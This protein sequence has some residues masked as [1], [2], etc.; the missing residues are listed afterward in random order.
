MALEPDPLTSDCE[1]SFPPLSKGGEEIVEVTVEVC[2]EPFIQV[3]VPGA[4]ASA[5]ADD[6]IVL[7]DTSVVLCKRSWAQAS[8]IAFKS[9]SS[10]GERQPNQPTSGW[11]HLAKAAPLPV[12]LEWYSKV[13]L[14]IKFKK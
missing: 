13:S 11:E 9:A 14:Q 10:S 3:K 7:L 6:V 5:R 4:V 2:T 8:E 1:P 12:C